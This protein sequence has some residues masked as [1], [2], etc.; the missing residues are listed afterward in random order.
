MNGTAT[1]VSLRLPQEWLELDPRADDMLEEIRRAVEGKWSLT[2]DDDRLVSL[3]APMAVEVRRL[4]AAE[5]VVLIGVYSQAIPVENDLPLVVT[6]HVVLAISP[7]LADIEAALGQ[8]LDP[9][10][11]R[12]VA[13]VE[14]AAGAGVRDDGLT[15]ITHPDWDGPVEA[16]QRRFC[17]PVPGHDRLAVLAFLTP[18]VELKEAFAPV[19]DA[20]AETLAFA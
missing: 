18:N 3:L 20:I 13:P 7:P 17:V 4:A 12:T 2:L 16:Y 8:L 1:S 9:T 19:F 5:E 11:G 10:G 6:G 14:L 15:T